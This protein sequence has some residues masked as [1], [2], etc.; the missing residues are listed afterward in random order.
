MK[1][2][3]LKENK[4]TVLRHYNTLGLSSAYFAPLIILSGDMSSNN[5]FMNYLSRENALV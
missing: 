2:L 3:S 1:I 4:S 5:R